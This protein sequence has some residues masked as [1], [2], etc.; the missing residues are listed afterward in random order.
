MNPISII[1]AIVTLVLGLLIGYIYR[2]NVGEKAIGSAEQKAKN[3][4]LDAE[5]KSETI[6]KEIVLEAKEEAHRLR[7]DIEREVRERRQEIQRKKE[8]EMKRVINQSLVLW[9]PR[10]LTD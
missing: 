3:L 4:I 10:Q 5:N 2:K 8:E 6:K 7:N 9:F 1:V